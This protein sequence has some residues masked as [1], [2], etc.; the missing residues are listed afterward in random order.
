[1]RYYDCPGPEGA[2]KENVCARLPLGE[3]E[4]VEHGYT[5]Y[6]V[7]YFRLIERPGAEP[8]RE[9]FF[10]RYRMT[11][12]VVLVGTAAP[13][14]TT[15]ATTPGSTPPSVTPTTVTPATAAP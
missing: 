4:E 12:T 1:V 9:R 2:D 15:G 10:W 3:T 8:E 5:G 11:P 7:E 6:D 13:T 14:T